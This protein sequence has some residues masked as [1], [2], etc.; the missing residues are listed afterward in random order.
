MKTLTFGRS[1]VIFKQGDFSKVMYCVESGKVGIYAGY[2]TEQEKLLKE[3][4]KDE[5]FGEMGLIEL[6]ARSATAVALEDDTSVSE[7]GDDDFNEFFGKD[8]ERTYRL[9]KTLS[10]RIRETDEKYRDVCRVVYLSHE[11]AESN[12]KRDDKVN[13][14][15][16]MICKE[17]GNFNTLW[18]D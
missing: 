15:L 13:Q 1:Q 12:T 16:D 2:G 6:Y 3:I 5:I 10:A 18:L 14:E 17:Y 7:I 4:G 11:A 9:L 8:H